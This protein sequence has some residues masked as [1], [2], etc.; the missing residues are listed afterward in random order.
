MRKIGN[1]YLLG[2]TEYVVAYHLLESNLDK[3]PRTIKEIEK[4]LGFVDRVHPY[5]R[6]ILNEYKKLGILYHA[7][8]KD[9][10]I[11]Y[12]VFLL[13]KKLLKQIVENSLNYAIAY[14]LIVGN[15]YDIPFPASIKFTSNKGRQNN[16][17]DSIP[18]K[19]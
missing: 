11:N 3:K 1:L 19:K 4:M 8:F 10:Y 5:V 16:A 15:D 14:N 7:G 12:A 18:E 9:H 2:A 13:N 6:H 17:K